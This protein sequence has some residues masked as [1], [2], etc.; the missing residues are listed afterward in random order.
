MRYPG[1][2]VKTGT[3]FLCIVPCFRRDGVW[4][5]AGVYPVHRYGAGMTK[6]ANLFMGHNIS[7]RLNND[8]EYSTDSE[9]SGQTMSHINIIYGQIL[10]LIAKHLK[11][12]I[13]IEYD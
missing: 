5:P 12:I 3:Y 11:V 7:I 13:L 10:Y 1:F 9:A 4:I 2:P 6:H 8:T